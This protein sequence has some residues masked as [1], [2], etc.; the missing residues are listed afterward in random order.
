MHNMSYNQ[1]YKIGGGLPAGAA[2]AALKRLVRRLLKPVTVL[3]LVLSSP[4]LWADPL[5]TYPLKIGDS[6]I[7]AELANTP[8]TRRKGLMHRPF[9]GKSSGMIFVF[10]KP[11]RISMWMKN[12]LIPLSVAFIDAQGH[13]LNIEDMEPHSEEV[14]SSVELA[15]YALEMNQGWFATH[16]IGDGDRVSG[17]ERLPRAK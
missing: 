11:R 9:L 6:S 17:L 16:G 3:V 8:Q 1:R 14:H 12:T 2:T 15:V 4:P 7:R 5:L 13:I 10:P